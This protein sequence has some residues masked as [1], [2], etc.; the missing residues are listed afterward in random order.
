MRYLIIIAA[1]L[2]A[3]AP[4]PSENRACAA[5]AEAH[6]DRVTRAATSLEYVAVWIGHYENEYRRCATTK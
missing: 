2:S 6:A 1:A 4:L 3:C 5:R